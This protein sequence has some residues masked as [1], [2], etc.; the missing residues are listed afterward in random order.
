MSAA[1]QCR[2][3]P[4]EGI[5]QKLL[6]AYCLQGESDANIT[7]EDVFPYEYFNSSSS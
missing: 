5:S 2:H 7:N 3:Q 1:F 4:S 6:I